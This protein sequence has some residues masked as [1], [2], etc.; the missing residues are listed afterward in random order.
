M[1]AAD[2]IL[3]PL[4]VSNNT[5]IWKRKNFK[6][7]YCANVARSLKTHGMNLVNLVKFS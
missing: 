4:R 5:I 6:K 7:I 3:H 2:A 1:D